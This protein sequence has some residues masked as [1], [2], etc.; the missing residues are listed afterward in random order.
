ML[1][2]APFSLCQTW[3]MFLNLRLY[4]FHWLCSLL[5]SSTVIS[6]WGMLCDS[7]LSCHHVTSIYLFSW[8]CI[9]INRIHQMYLIGWKH[10]WQVS[11]VSFLLWNGEMRT[12]L[13]SSF[14][15]VLNFHSLNV[16]PMSLGEVMWTN[17]ISLQR[18]GLNPMYVFEMKLSILLN[19]N[20][21]VKA[22][23]LK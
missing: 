16:K 20:I 15:E 17:L 22:L 14:P 9:V 6:W 21:W 4:T 19:Q 12:L 11:S 2:S 3:A 18:L 13:I 10:A 5:E 23:E 7:C 1:T 8:V